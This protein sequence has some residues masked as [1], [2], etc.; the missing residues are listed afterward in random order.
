MKATK[1]NSRT[2]RS[3]ALRIK[4]K[5]RVQSEPEEINATKNLKSAIQPKGKYHF[6]VM[7]FAGRLGVKKLEAA[8][9]EA[10]DQLFDGCV[11]ERIALFP[12]VQL[13]KPS[14]RWPVGRTIG[15]MLKRAR[16]SALVET[17][18][19]HGDFKHYRAFDIES[20][21]EDVRITQ[22]FS[23]HN[24]ATR[25]KVSALLEQLKPGGIR[26]IVLRGVPIG[27]LVCGENNVLANRQSDG[28]KPYIRHDLPGS[29]FPHCPVIFNGAHDTMGNWNKLDPRFRHLSTNRR[30]FFYTTNCD[31]WTWGNS[32][33]RA[34][35]D[36]KLVADSS[37]TFVDG[38]A[39]VT[40]IDD[41]EDW[42]GLRIDVPG[43]MLQEPE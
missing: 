11:G 10:L 42:L 12:G 43:A 25:E 17:Y 18:A 32:T 20:G 34:Y 30:W 36:G 26:T 9:C 5:M 31:R 35:C 19:L 39:R 40:L 7:S 28:N 38:D 24:N 37:G 8:A 22:K 23:N 29:I 27:L 4:G 15:A 6:G 2:G 13:F 16:V 41:N 21:W 33:A 14:A 1:T 3:K